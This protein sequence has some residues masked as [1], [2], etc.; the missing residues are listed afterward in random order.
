[1]RNRFRESNQVV[2]WI[3]M[4]TASYVNKIKQFF[5]VEI[6]ASEKSADISK[7]QNK[8]VFLPYT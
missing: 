7:I 2:Q 3:D 5:Q 8:K 4:K 6:G 1:M